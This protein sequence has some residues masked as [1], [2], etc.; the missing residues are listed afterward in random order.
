MTTN[1][2]KLTVAERKD[3]ASSQT[4]ALRDGGSVPAVI[5]GPQQ[6]P[7][8]ISIDARDFE[9][10]WKQAGESTLITLTGVG[11]D[12]EVLIKDVQWHPLS[13][14]A[15]HVDFYAFERGKLLTVS[16]PVEFIGEAP[17]EKLGG[18]VVKS[19]YEVEMEVRPSEIP[20]TLEVDLTQLVDLQS[21]ITVGDLKLPESASTTLEANDAIASITEAVE[22]DL[23]APVG[24]AMAA[25]ETEDDASAAEGDA[26]E[27]EEKKEE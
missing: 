21:V 12:K 14:A 20:H 1:Q 3:G 25:E 7:L 16:V 24:D 10:V 23:S 15:M 13:D 27:E 19:V 9:K 2:I 6:E 22:E 18:I 26:E 17:A 4:T 11:E 5:Y 8:S